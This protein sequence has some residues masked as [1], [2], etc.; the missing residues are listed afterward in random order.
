MKFDIS[1]AFSG[2]KKLMESHTDAGSSVA[3]SG[4]KGFIN[5]N[6][7]GDE[8]VKAA[9]AP[10]PSPQQKEKLANEELLNRLQQQIYADRGKL[11]S[12][13]K[14]NY[15]GK[16]IGPMSSMTQNA[17]SMREQY[18]NKVPKQ[19]K[20]ASLLRKEGKGWSPEQTQGM[21]DML[22]RGD[23]SEKMVMNRLQ[24]Q[25]GKNFG[26]EGERGNKLQGKIG[27]DINEN[28]EMSKVNLKNMGDE[29]KNLENRRTT[30]GVSSLQKAG[31]LKSARREA[32]MKQLEEFGNQEH[33]LNN[34]KLQ[35]EKDVFDEEQAAPF[36]KMDM[37]TRALGGINP[38][39]SHPDKYKLENQLLQKINNAYNQPH[40]N[41][42]GQRVADIDADTDASFRLAQQINPKYKDVFAGDRKA[43]EQDLLQNQLSDKVYNR[44]PEAIEPLMGNLDALARRQ[45]KTEAKNI[46][47]HYARQGTYGSG[48]HKAATEQALRD[49]MRRVQ[50]EREGALVSGVKGQRDLIGQEDANTMNRYG[51]MADEGAKE[52]GN[53]LQE[54]ERLN[55]QGW[56]KR[57]NRQGEENQA[58]QSWYGQ[59]ANE[60]PMENQGP[61]YRN[62][63]MGPFEDLAKGY[64]TDLT[65]LFSQPALFSENEK[66]FNAYKNM[67]N[68][69]ILDYPSYLRQN[70]NAQMTSNR[71]AMERANQERIARE[72]KQRMNDYARVQAQNANKNRQDAINAA[73]QK[74]RDEAWSN[75]SGAAKQG[76]EWTDYGGWRTDAG[77]AVPQARYDQLYNLLSNGPGLMTQTN[78]NA[79]YRS[80]INMSRQQFENNPATLAW[81][82]PQYKWS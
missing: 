68:K 33:V 23:T 15:P 16:T 70:H 76:R 36:R 5:R 11:A 31:G 82:Q 63:D 25:F 32:L 4:M 81:A 78:P 13:N 6:Q 2:L 37:A 43:I 65:G 60:W 41:Y 75:Y 1:P 29:I 59:L 26:Y 19:G 18:A 12:G 79:D 8:V 54:N 71:E 51:L 62:V 42:P 38:D 52:F 46:G 39:E 22:K 10:P 48:A 77:H 14:P 58:M 56:R 72:G 34:M 69:N 57:A 45:L 61:A 40:L 50:A 28:L 21:L 3:G 7:N 30:K 66:A 49:V 53:I 24:K 35:S 67:E 73:K 27:K 20:I 47:G 44:I 80:N 74:E 55:K 17:R 9:P 64:G